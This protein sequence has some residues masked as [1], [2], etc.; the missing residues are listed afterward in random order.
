[1]GEKN[2]YVALLVAWYLSGAAM[3]S[4]CCIIKSLKDHVLRDVRKKQAKI[5]HIFSNFSM[6]FACQL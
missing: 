5:R 4:M 1:V 6:F 3:A 2:S